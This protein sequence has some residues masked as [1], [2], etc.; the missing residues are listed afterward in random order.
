MD[1]MREK[2][3]DAM[4]NV[5][6]M[7]KVKC[8][9]GMHTIVVTTSGRMI[10]LDH[11]PREKLI[12]TMREKADMP[13]EHACAKVLRCWSAESYYSGSLPVSLRT[14]F[15]AVQQ[16]RSKRTNLK[17]EAK[18][19]ER[20]AAM[21]MRDRFVA[22]AAK[23]MKETLSAADYRRSKRHHS[24]SFDVCSRDAGTALSLR[25]SKNPQSGRVNSTTLVLTAPLSW[26]SH[27][28]TKGFACVEGTV[29][30]SILKPSALG[31][32]RVIAARQA[33]GYTIKPSEATVYKKSDGKW[34]LVWEQ[35]TRRW[36]SENGADKLPADSEE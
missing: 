31:G 22:R 7:A 27:I 5:H 25:V 14:A 10:L 23:A 3:A 21:S 19:A 24:F 28:Y 12:D 9:D 32:Y 6:A 11:P 33:E 15:E 8:G 34:T 17:E 4:R 2:L 20:L 16:R 29:V 36:N 30:L 13:P 18:A 1:K 26:Y 35:S